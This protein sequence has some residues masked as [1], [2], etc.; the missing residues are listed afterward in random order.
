MLKN[1]LITFKFFRFIQ[2]GFYLDFIFK[3]ISEIFIRNILIYS[4]IFFGE[5]YMIEYF[6]KKVIDSFIFNSNKNSF[7]NLIE[8]KY[9]IQILSLII[10]LIFI[11]IFI[12]LYI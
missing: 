6:T 12:I 4:S 5:K 2:S 3:K 11:S 7:L 9:F 10:Y 1:N 8:T